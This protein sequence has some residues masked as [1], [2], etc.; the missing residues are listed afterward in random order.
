LLVIFFSRTGNIFDISSVSIRNLK[1]KA[2]IYCSSEKNVL[3]YTL[4]SV[5]FHISFSLKFVKKNH[6]FFSFVKE[7]LDFLKVVCLK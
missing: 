1:R 5:S 6:I 2:E 3:V 4:P 7:F